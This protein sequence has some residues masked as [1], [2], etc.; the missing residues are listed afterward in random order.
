[1][2]LVPV[3]IIAVP[4]WSTFDPVPSWL[5]WSGEGPLDLVNFCLVFFGCYCVSEKKIGIEVFLY[6]GDVIYNILFILY[7]YRPN[8]HTVCRQDFNLKSGGWLQNLLLDHYFSVFHRWIHV[9][10]FH[11]VFLLGRR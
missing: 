10:A 3:T 2:G 9:N 4:L 8:I 11:D 7:L 6:F 5:R 1:M